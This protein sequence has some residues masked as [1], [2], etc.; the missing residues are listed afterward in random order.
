MAVSM[1]IRVLHH[2]GGRQYVHN[3]LF[4]TDFVK[5]HNYV[6]IK[7]MIHE[8]QQAPAE[9]WMQALDFMESV[10]QWC[11][12]CYQC[13]PHFERNPLIE[14]EANMT[15]YITTYLTMYIKVA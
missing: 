11:T 13:D 12:I 2:S 1:H 6:I 7:V 8:L 5:A 14:L 15:I 3:I 9:I 4:S 10:R